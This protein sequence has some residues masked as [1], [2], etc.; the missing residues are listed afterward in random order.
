[1]IS[2][3][4]DL[5]RARC[6]P[7]SVASAHIEEI[8]K[9]SERAASLTRQL[10]AFSRKQVLQPKTLNLNERINDL[11]KMLQR[12]IGDDVELIL[13]LGAPLQVIQADPGQIDQVIINLA[14]NA[15]DAM[16]CGGKF[17]IETSSAELDDTSIPRQHRAKAGKYVLLKMTDTGHG[18]D[19]ETLSHIFEPFFT[20][21]QPG[22]GT[23]LGL[24][25][26]HG[27][28][29]QSG[30]YIWVYSEPGRGTTFK[31]YLPAIAQSTFAQAS[32]P[33]EKTL[34]RGSATVLLAEDDAPMRALTRHLLEA[35]GY[36]VLE[37]CDGDQAITLAQAH[38][39]EIDLLLTDVVMPRLS[40]PGLV[41][42][43]RASQPGIK[44]VYM[45]GYTDEL[46]AHHGALDSGI[47]FLEKPFTQ[48]SLLQAV[49]AALR[50]SPAVSGESAISVHAG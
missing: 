17:I 10:L 37:A 14:V 6:A 31:I 38:K 1:V 4:T 18:M 19:P 35:Q 12:L 49:Q 20:T 7:D 9:A 50:S 15:R 44:I 3:Y 36:R 41:E 47:A 46:L 30:G 27:I 22:K 21:K 16:P 2:G 23:G 13:R 45:S 24:S 28:I 40:G 32:H 5:V 33:S 42:R 8:R 29:N 34:A 48:E 43:L 26:V 25:T 39:N 11:T